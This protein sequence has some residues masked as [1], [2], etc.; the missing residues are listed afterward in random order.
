[1]E[2][3][4]AREREVLQLIA[5]HLRVRQIAAA[6]AISPFTVRKHRANLCAKLQLRGTAQLIAYA[7]DRMSDAASV[8]H[9]QAGCQAADV[10]RA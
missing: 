5:R 4:T 9:F 6:L 1:M 2:S 3:L 7:Q 10:A 8:R